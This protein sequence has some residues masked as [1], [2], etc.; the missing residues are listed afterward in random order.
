M[1]VKRRVKERFISRGVYVTNAKEGD[2]SVAWRQ[3]WQTKDGEAQKR[4][5][6]WCTIGM[7]DDKVQRNIYAA[8]Q[9]STLRKGSASAQD[10]T[11]TR[12]VRAAIG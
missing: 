5:G 9:N 1:P 4:I 6:A 11:H 12:D 10:L 7:E 8:E 2:I 3:T